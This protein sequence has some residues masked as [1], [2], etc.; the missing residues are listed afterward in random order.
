MSASPDALSVCP[1][2]IARL[3]A[4]TLFALRITAGHGPSCRIF[5]PATVLGQVGHL[6]GAGLC[7]GERE[8]YT[9]SGPLWAHSPE[10]RQHHIN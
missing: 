7:Q 6:L 2:S 1:M 9:S 3:Q 4:L 10:G 5:L 8:D